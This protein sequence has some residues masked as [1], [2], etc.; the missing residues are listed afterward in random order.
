M[1]SLIIQ[2]HRNFYSYFKL[3]NPIL[4]QKLECFVPYHKPTT[5]SEL[6]M[7]STSALQKSL[8]PVNRGVPTLILPT[9]GECEFVR[10][11]SWPFSFREWRW[12]EDGRAGK[13]P[14]YWYCCESLY[15]LWAWQRLVPLGWLFSLW[16]LLRPDLELPLPLLG[17]V[18]K[19][20]SA[21][22]PFCL[23][24]GPRVSLDI[25]S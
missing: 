9:L 7:K 10:G 12:G 8:R 11:G 17:N 24:Q 16:A 25:S 14:L 20:V 19:S 15:S 23:A 22:L 5:Q 1:I 6:K 13:F 18:H 3:L 2:F 21:F 4:V